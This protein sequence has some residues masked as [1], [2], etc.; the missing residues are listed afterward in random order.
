VTIL[1]ELL[2]REI[3]KSQRQL[4]RLL[5][6]APN[7]VCENRGQF[8]A[9]DLVE[10]RLHLLAA[11]EHADLVSHLNDVILSSWSAG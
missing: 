6:R 3:V 1:E 11:G 10:I 4:S 2:G 5:G 9:V 7:Y 8:A